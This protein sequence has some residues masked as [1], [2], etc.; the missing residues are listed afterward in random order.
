MLTLPARTSRQRHTRRAAPSLLPRRRARGIH[1]TGAPFSPLIDA[2]A[3]GLLLGCPTHG[4]SPRPAPGASR[5]TAS[6]TTSAS[7]RMT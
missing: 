7:A 4:C 5:T 3:A 2:K 1:E 6:D